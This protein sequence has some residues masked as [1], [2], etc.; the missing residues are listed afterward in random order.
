MVQPDLL[1]AC[2]LVL[3]SGVLG[4]FR[5]QCP[6]KQVLGVGDNSNGQLGIPGESEVGAAPFRPS[7]HVRNVRD[8]MKIT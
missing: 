5:H 2:S 6:S 8:R 1:S 7:P 3:F 4:Q